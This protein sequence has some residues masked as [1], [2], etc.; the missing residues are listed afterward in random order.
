MAKGTRGGK[1]TGGA[2]QNNATSDRSAFVWDIATR[3]TGG[4]SYEDRESAV[5]NFLKANPFE[6]KDELSADIDSANAEIKIAERRFANIPIYFPG[7][8]IPAGYTEI[9][10]ATT[11][12]KGFALFSNNQSRFSGNRK[13]ILVAIPDYWRSTNIPLF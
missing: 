10:G 4:L 9:Q 3:M 2:Q 1:R 11:A 8:K 12:P 7:Q 6:D 13:T 5:D